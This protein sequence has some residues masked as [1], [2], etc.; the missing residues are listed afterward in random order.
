MIVVSVKDDIQALKKRLGAFDS[1]QI[2]FVIAKALTN[3]AQDAKKS[4]REQLPR[5][6]DRP[7]PYTLNS[8]Y[9]APASKQRLEATVKLK[10]QAGGKGTPANKY[11]APS[12]FGGVRNVKR[13]ERLMSAKGILPDG[14]TIAPGSGAKLDSY[15]NLARSQYGAIISQLGGQSI[16]ATKRKRKQA[17]RFFVPG[18]TSKLTPGVWAREGAGI[19][20]VVFF[21]SVPQYRKQ[22][23]F[24]GDINKTIQARFGQNLTAAMDYALATS[25]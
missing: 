11:L 9:V 15:G 16:A 2:P 17:A 7:T 13:V 18:E 25:R 22:F 20:P 8:L 4:L 12:I 10:D 21:V 3:T 6:F 5:V 19:K 23:D 1:R 14:M 24:F